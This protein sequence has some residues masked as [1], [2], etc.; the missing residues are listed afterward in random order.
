MKILV[1]S[2]DK[3]EDTFY[4]FHHCIEKYWPDH[5]EV[6]YKTETIENPYYKTIPTNY[7]ISKW[8]KGIREA[9][10]QIDDNII[11]WMMDDCFI[12]KP[13]DVERVKFT[14]EQISGNI[15]NF[16]YEKS[17]DPNDI[18][19]NLPGFKKRQHGSMYEVS[20]MCGLWDKNKLKNILAPDSD[21]WTVEYAQNN[22]GYDFYINSGDYIIDWGYKTY[23]YAGI[24]KGK[25]C[26]EIVPF[27]ESEGIKIDYSIRGFE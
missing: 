7:E 16:N 17:F 8:T 1:C 2:C 9:L 19:T 10:D 11:L 5:P 21:P 6:I 24:N 3:N 4:P 26:R 25:W 13:V 27:F 23:H 22:C 18:R 20:I 15:A 14:T 12:R